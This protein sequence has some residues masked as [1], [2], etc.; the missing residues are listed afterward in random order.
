MTSD[1]LPA[2][3]ATTRARYEGRAAQRKRTSASIAR[4]GV[5]HTDAPN[6]VTRRLDRLG[7]DWQ[8]AS[9]LEHGAATG[10]SGSRELDLERLI[11]RGT[12][13]DSGF[14]ATGVSAARAVARVVTGERW[15]NGFLIAPFLLLTAHHVLPG[16]TAAAGATVE[17]DGVTVQA[18]PEVFF[19]G[20]LGLDFTV[21]ALDDSAELP[22]HLPLIEHQGKAVLGERLTVVRVPAHGPKQF[23][24]RDHVLVDVLDNF[25]HYETGTATAGAPV[26]NDQWEVVALH[27]SGVPHTDDT[28]RPLSVDGGPWSPELG[29]HRLAWH[30]G[31]GVR[32]SRILKTLR[33]RPLSA[34]AARLRAQVFDA[35]PMSVEADAEL[36]AALVNLDIGRSRG[37]Y[38]TVTDRS[39]RERYYADIRFP[40]RQSLRELVERTHVRRPAYR[41]SRMLYPWVDLHPDLKL[42][43]LRSGTAAD[44]EDFIRA[45]VDAEAARARRLR[46]LVAVGLPDPSTLLAEFDII[47]DTLPFNCEHVV[48][49]ALFES[50]EP[51][52]GDLHHLFARSTG[53]ASQSWERHGAVARA[54]LYFL[55]RYPGFVDERRLSELVSWHR[56]DPVDE[57]ELHRNAAIAEIQG[58][59]NPFIDHPDWALDI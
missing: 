28:G 30:A 2:R 52:R 15:G 12:V 11:G 31:E 29:E 1:A 27:H 58:N 37:Y 35:A 34:S 51:M 3:L 39:A 19:L 5:L 10:R 20:D 21:V 33:E 9:A 7:L 36:Q 18:R 4:R 42:R 54:T 49:Q 55:V 59:R 56:N 50:R 47:E 16:V 24:L 8:F 45:D 44:P 46:D 23:A 22:P 48:P 6:R 32:I 53:D 26:F 13:V 40:T 57:Y 17:F 41:P 14:L 38:D 25:V 43:S